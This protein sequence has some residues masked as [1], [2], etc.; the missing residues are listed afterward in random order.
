[1]AQF[2]W[3][4]MDHWVTSSAQGPANPQISVEAMDRYVKQI[5]GLGFTGFDTFDF[6]LGKYIELFGSVRNFEVFLQER[7]MEKLTGIFKA[8]PYA[9]KHQTIHDRSC[10]DNIFREMA[11]FVNMV[12]GTGVQTY[13]IMPAHTYFQVEPVTDEKIKIMA[14]LWNRVGEMTLSRGIKLACHHE[15]WCGIKTEE[16]I[17]KFYAMTDPRY[18]FYLCDTA[19]HVIAGV[20]P[21]KTYMKLHDRCAGFHFKD[22]HDVDHR[23]E[24][25]SPP[26]A[27]LM[28]P[29]VHR[30]FWE[31]GTPQGLVDYPLLIRAMKEYDY[32]GWVG[33]E[34]DKADIGGNYAE[35]A[36]M[37]MWYIKNVLEKI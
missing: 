10:H 4:Y 14:E 1:M 7:G 33:V 8:I 20:D 29:S 3:N 19:Q 25:R 30:W 22:T 37:S 9:T 32:N 15:F 17:D 36:C 34:I 5:A 35:S 28:A 31:M 27:E 12:E 26:D 23:G 2:K 24:Y 13:V 21:I 18:V 11:H 16:E 6:R